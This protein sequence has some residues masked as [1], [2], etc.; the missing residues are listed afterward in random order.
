[1]DTEEYRTLWK[2]AIRL[3]EEEQNKEEAISFVM[4]YHD[5]PRLF[6]SMDDRSLLLTFIGL[7]VYE[8]KF[9][10]KFGSTTPASFC[11]RE[12]LNRLSRLDRD[13]VYDI[14]D[15]AAEYSDNSYV[16]MGNYRGYGPRQYFAFWD[17]YESRVAL[18]RQAKEERL[19]RKRAEGR[20]KV[21]AAKLRHLE[22]LNTIQ[23]LREKTIEDCILVIEKSDESVFYYYELIEEWFNNKSL[24]D[25]QKE[26]ILSM[27]P[28]NS[29]RHNIRKRKN[30]EEK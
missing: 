5:K 11:Y 26:K 22:R 6:D 4:H 27:F 14:G 29:T 1:M 13:F 16:P 18:E 15:W 28:I 17:D 10:M 25:N 8:K 30:L 24:S 12:L 2:E 9:H 23:Q 3:C 20:A 7:V 21:E 19:E